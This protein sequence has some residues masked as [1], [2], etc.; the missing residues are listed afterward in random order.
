MTRALVIVDHGSRL[1]E[2]HAHLEKIAAQVRERAPGWRVYAAHLELADP[3]LEETLDAC[4]RDAV[5]EVTV[6]PL[7]LLPGRHLSSEL[8]SRVRRAAAENPALR[9]R[10]SSALGSDPRIAEWLLRSCGIE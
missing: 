1:P 3:S 4:A 8:P 9:I 2:A 6:H 5:S 7:L 10:I